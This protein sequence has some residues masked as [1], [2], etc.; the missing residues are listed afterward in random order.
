MD[1]TPASGVTFERLNGDSAIITALEA[2][3][4]GVETYV[5]LSAAVAPPRTPART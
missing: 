4:A 3:R 1:E 2:E 5:F